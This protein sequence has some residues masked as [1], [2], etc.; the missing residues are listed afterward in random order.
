[1][2]SFALTLAAVLG[3]ASPAF[4]HD[5]WGNGKKVTQ[6]REVGEFE[7]LRLEGSLDV[8]FTVGP[9]RSVSVTLDENLQPLVELKVEKGV[10]VV[11]LQDSSYHGKGYVTV[12]NPVL[13]AV[14]L[15]GSGDVAIS[16]A[17]GEQRLEIRGSGDIDWSGEATGIDIDIHGSG[18]VTLSGKADLLKVSIAGSGDLAGKRLTTKSAEISIR[19]SGDAVLRLDGGSLNATVA[20]SGD[21]EWYGVAVVERTSVHGSGSI[22]H[23]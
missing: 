10:L 7:A 5:T 13:R 15:H 17:K 4:A 8:V 23:L 20:G 12:S 16:G 9:E 3:A 18:D 19:G 22:E 11:S 1:M 21:I 6:P 14:S 2:R